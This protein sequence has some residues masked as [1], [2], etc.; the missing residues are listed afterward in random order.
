MPTMDNEFNRK[1]RKTKSPSI[2]GDDAAPV[3]RAIKSD[4]R[5]SEPFLAT[6]LTVDS[7]SDESSD[8]LF[9]R[10]AGF[11]RARTIEPVMPDVRTPCSVASFQRLGRRF[12]PIDADR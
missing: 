3:D 5:P 4:P 9:G 11:G 7:G 6:A 10:Q 1:K 12:D 2:D 8:P